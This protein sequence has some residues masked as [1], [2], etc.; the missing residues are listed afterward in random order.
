MAGRFVLDK[1]TNG[2][3]YFNLKAGNH[4]TILT[5][6]LY[7]AKSGALNGID[8]VRENAPLDNR[9]DKKDGAH[10]SFNLKAK[11]GQ[12]IGRSETYT[13]SAA[14][15]KGIESVKTNGPTT[16]LDDQTGDD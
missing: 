14:R 7:K 15:D 10:Y 8:S 11:N 16:R 13:T 9:Y 12:V 3:Y 1:S 5:S 6:E 4:E 2:Q